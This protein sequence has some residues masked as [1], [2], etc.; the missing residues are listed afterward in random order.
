M[1]NSFFPLLAA[2]PP[3]TRTPSRGR[4][5][6]PD[7]HV[8][9]SVADIRM[10]V[11]VR[12]TPPG[13]P[14][15]VTT[16]PRTGAVALE[17]GDVFHYPSAVV[18]GSDQVVAYDALCAP[19]VKHALTG[20]DCTLVA[21]GQTGSGKTHTMFG[22]PGCLVEARVR[23]WREESHSSHS[24]HSSDSSDSPDAPRD[25]GVF[26]RAVLELMRTPGVRSIH[27]SAV[28]VY[29]ENVFDLMN[30]REQLSL[31]SSRSKIGRRASG[32]AESGSDDVAGDRGAQGGVHPSCCTCHKCFAL[33]E[34]DK[35]KA[36]RA[37][38][39]RLFEKT[40]RLETFDATGATTTR[41][42]APESLAR[43]ARSVEAT[44]TSGAHLLNDRSS[45][46]HCLV[47]VR[48]KLADGA[49]AR[50]TFAD[51]AGSER[52]ARTGATGDA[53]REARAINGSLSAL[54]R[55][56]KALGEISTIQRRRSK[57]TLSTL[58]TPQHV[59]YRDAALT[60]LLR[61][62]FG[63]GSCASVVIAVAG[64]ADHADETACS[65][66]F[67]ERM[68]L[69]K[70]APTRVLGDI[71]AR[72]HHPGLGSPTRV[73]ASSASRDARLKT[74]RAALA[75]ATAELASLARRG[76]AG[77]FVKDGPVTEVRSLRL[78]MEKLKCADDAT[79]KL[80]VRLA[81]TAGDISKSASG[82]ATKKTAVAALRAA[83]SASARRA[84]DL[85]AVVRRQKT[86]KAI[87]AEPTVPYAKKAA[88]VRQIRSELEMEE[89]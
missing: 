23:R 79:A 45:R 84:E 29:H 82:A 52:V 31:G 70:N 2:Q 4:R 39:E 63:G 72:A 36:A 73:A 61:D 87:W 40:S 62:A 17:N 35:K 78:G 30:G 37:R 58:S 41:L 46:S 48:A 69:V 13:D 34:R 89:S 15:A 50:L 68:C 67:G 32:A 1:Q 83:L 21:Y 19:L 60:M 77:G 44:R 33:Q 18:V 59:P 22:P 54:G 8:T 10:S 12:P 27:A 26:P 3:P 11:R 25:W 38:P 65:L 85:R 75:S 56:V 88:E 42:D 5:I 9:M 16:D 64:G 49:A 74:L 43:F 66:R 6:L 71:N 86:I 55:V 7:G 47:R 28:E 24:S 57:E 51:L 53:G 76:D 81:E 14:C 20:Y 80:R